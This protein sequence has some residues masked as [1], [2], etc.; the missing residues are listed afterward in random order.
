MNLSEIAAAHP[1]KDAIVLA[2]GS[3]RVSF[4]D[5]DRRSVRLADFFA[6]QGLAP[7]DHIAIV[8]ENRPEFLEVAWAA[9]RC[10]LMYT[11]VNWH[12]TAAEAEYVV[13][14]CGARMLISGAGVGGLAARILAG[15]PGVETAIG[16]GGPIDGHLDYESIVEGPAAPVAHEPVEGYYFFY[17]SGTTGRPK[18]IEP[19]HDFPPFGTGL[20]LDQMMPAY[21]VDS[22]TVYLCPAP[23]YHA[24]PLGWSLAMQRQ[25]A[26]VVVMPSFDAQQCLSAIEEHS[27]THAQFVPTMF[28]RMLKLDPAVRS[29]FDVTSLRLVVHA[30]A[31][32]PV[33]VKQQ[34]IEWFGPVL[35]E[36]YSGSEGNGMTAITSPEWLSHPGSVGRAVYG[37]VHIVDD[38]GTELPTGEVGTVYFAGT[39]EF[40]YLNDPAKTEGARD[41]RGWQT[42]GDLGHLDADGYLYLSDRR[43]D[44]ILSGGV[45]I[46]P[47]EIESALIMHPAVADVAV[48]GLPDDEMGER[49]HAVVELAEGVTAGDTVADA[50][51]AHSRIHLAG[52]KQPRSMEFVDEV[53]R[54]PAGKLLRRR[55]REASPA[56]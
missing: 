48:I 45:N 17:S 42:I 51:I 21:G 40:R 50:L 2:D 18:G 25:G 55:L 46:Y 34:M 12:L 52:F 22:S 10:G 23:L 44:L 30:G 43:S 49:V 7:G 15:A 13:N 32:C 6:A 16:V 28:V 3:A 27:V 8:M 31:P 39:R 29:L 35:F 56:S 1:D 9:Q 5:L 53:P 26:T 24:A 37:K 47:Q 38:A 19:T 20:G 33:P 41:Q 54:T 36:Y 4:A 11:P 14:D